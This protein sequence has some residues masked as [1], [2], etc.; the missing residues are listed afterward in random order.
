MSAAFRESPGFEHSARVSTRRPLHGRPA[1]IR[2][3]ILRLAAVSSASPR[4]LEEK[5]KVPRQTV[6]AATAALQRQ[7]VDLSNQVKV[8]EQW[9]SEYP[10]PG[11]ILRGCSARHR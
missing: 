9:E 6:A 10:G 8:V 5:L 4:E 11:G 2:W 1:W 7:A 3:A